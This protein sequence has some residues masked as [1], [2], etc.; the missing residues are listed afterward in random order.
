MGPGETRGQ[1]ATKRRVLKVEGIL[2]K[3]SADS[4]LEK[5]N[6]AVLALMAPKDG[7]LRSLVV[8]PPDDLER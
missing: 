1:V 7:L 6:D 8:F 5:I 2:N 3:R 4:S